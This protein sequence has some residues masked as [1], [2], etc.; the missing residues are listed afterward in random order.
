VRWAATLPPPPPAA[1]SDR[2]PLPPSAR[3]RTAGRPVRAH[4]ADRVF[5]E[6]N[7]PLSDLAERA[8][9]HPSTAEALL[10]LEA[11]RPTGTPEVP[12][13]AKDVLTALRR[14]SPEQ[15]ERACLDAL[16]VVGLPWL[17]RATGVRP[18]AV[19][20]A[21]LD[22]ELRARFDHLDL[23]PADAPL[24]GSLRKLARHG[25]IA[26]ARS[27]ELVARRIRAALGRLARAADPVLAQQVARR[28]DA[29]VLCPLVIAVTTWPPSRPSV[30]ITAPREMTV[31]GF[32]RSDLED[33]AGPWRNALPE[34][35]ELGADLDAF[36]DR[37]A[38]D[39]LRVPAAWLGNGGW[40][41]LWQRATR[42]SPRARAALTR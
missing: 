9:T 10:T 23:L 13:F 1:P 29:T 15:I 8:L 21:A 16:P 11:V 41:A 36:W 28:A 38:A 4:R 24:P 7:G 30:P 32:P 27:M 35:G 26:P 6:L 14:L 25:A 34:A 33:P 19:A 3:G 42:S 12:H 5:R 40:P 37:I 18:L 31:P 20:L 22:P 39:G 17:W 2:D